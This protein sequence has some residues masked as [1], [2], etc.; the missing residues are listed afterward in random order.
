MEIKIIVATHKKYWMP[1]DTMYTPIH[2]GR[3]GKQDIGYVGDD[4]GEN[5]S[6]KNAYYC[7]LTG[8]Y[9]AWKNI[10]AEYIG[11]VHYRRHFAMKK[12][13]KS[14]ESKRKAILTKKELEEVFKRV[15]VVLPNQRKYYI[16]TNRSH[17]NHAHHQEDLDMIEEIIKARYPEYA[18]AFQLIMNRTQAHMFNMFIMKREKY[19]EYCK[20]LF[21]MLEKLEARLNQRKTEI[22][23]RL[24]GYIGEVLLDV[25]IE[26][27]NIQYEE[28]DFMFMEQQNWLKKGLEF[29]KRK[30]CGQI[31]EALHGH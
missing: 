12:Y 20:W 4:S 2:V 27:N 13:G 25:W 26:K 17:Y 30:I 14:I 29:L 11:L 9:W 10:E 23:Q 22:E 31:R 7:E 3:Y 15:D 28:I 6:E 1:E 24:C 18:E 8:L 21:S 16:E 19:D 5:I